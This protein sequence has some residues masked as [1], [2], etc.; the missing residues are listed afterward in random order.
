MIATPLAALPYLPSLLLWLSLTLALYLLVCARIVGSWQGAVWLG[1]SFVTFGNF[2]AVQNGYLSAALLGGAL[3]VLPTRPILAGALL[4]LLS[5]KP[6]LGMLVPLALIAG[7][8]WRTFAAAGVTVAVVALLSLGLFGLDTWQAFLDNLARFSD[9]LASDQFPIAHKLHTAF[10]AM[11]TLGASRS[12]A[13]LVQVTLTL[14]LVAAIV[15]VWRS[16]APHALKAALLATAVVMASPYVFFYD[17]TMLAV[18]QA[19]L[20][21]HWLATS[22][23]ERKVYAL[24]VV[25]VVAMLILST[26]SP[27]GFGSGLILLM[28]VLREAWPYVRLTLPRLQW[29]A[30]GAR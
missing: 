1:A 21:R 6:H 10:G 29:P 5:F 25:N 4:G 26:Q 9:H 24:A 30:I 22:F 27:V 3:L 14:S 8:H 7:G 16:A 19:F 28:L 2:V 12:T 17:L 18:T 23:D 20:I 15:L 13:M 11:L